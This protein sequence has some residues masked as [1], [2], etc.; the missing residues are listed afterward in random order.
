MLTTQRAGK[1]KRNLA[2]YYLAEVAV[3]T[4]VWPGLARAHATKF[5][6]HL[7]SRILF[8]QLSVY[9]S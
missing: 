9:L 7:A 1:F 8:D 3:M 2:T 5:L 6:S 4:L